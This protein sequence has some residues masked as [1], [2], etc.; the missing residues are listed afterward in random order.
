MQYDLTVYKHVHQVNSQFFI[1]DIANYLCIRCKKIVKFI[2]MSDFAVKEYSNFLICK[3]RISD[4]RKF[5]Y[6]PITTKNRICY[7]CYASTRI[8]YCDMG[9]QKYVGIID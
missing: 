2:D 5:Y 4:L 1:Q 3:G 7:K 9:G 8:M 6:L